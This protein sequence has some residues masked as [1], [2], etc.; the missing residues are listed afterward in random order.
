MKSKIPSKK[1]F[2]TLEM[3]FQTRIEVAKQLIE[4]N[5]DE[6]ALATLKANYDSLVKNIS[7]LNVNHY[8][9]KMRKAVEAYNDAINVEGFLLLGLNNVLFEHDKQ[10]AFKNNKEM[11][12]ER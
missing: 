3:L 11:R 1:L 9:P 7:L 5:L 12:D 8:S 6:L 2:D 10:K 4:L